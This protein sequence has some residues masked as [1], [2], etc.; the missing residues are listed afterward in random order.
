MEVKRKKSSYQP[1][2]KEAMLPLRKLRYVSGS[3]VITVPKNI[4][5]DMGLKK[6][7]TIGVCIFI[8]KKKFTDESENS[9]DSTNSTDEEWIK[10]TKKER[11]KYEAYMKEKEGIKW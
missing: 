3:Y 5:E 6:G 1:W 7:N 2:Y 4:V 9:T 10:M 8:R 11:I